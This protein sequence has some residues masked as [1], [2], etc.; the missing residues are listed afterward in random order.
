M[1]FSLFHHRKFFVVA[2]ALFIFSVFISPFSAFAKDDPFVSLQKEIKKLETMISSSEFPEGLEGKCS[3]ASG[4]KLSTDYKLS[5][6]RK[7]SDLSLNHEYA[8]ASKC[9]NNA[10][11]KSEE[12]LA[13]QVKA[14]ASSGASCSVTE[15]WK[16]KKQLEKIVNMRNSLFSRSVT[17]TDFFKSYNSAYCEED[18]RSK[19]F[20]ETSSLWK[21]FKTESLYLM[22]EMKRLDAGSISFWSLDKKKK[23]NITARANARAQN[24]VKDFA[25]SIH[26]EIYDP[27][28]RSRS[29]V[30][31]NLS[32]LPKGKSHFT[33]VGYSWADSF[34]KKAKEDIEKKQQEYATK[35]AQ[36]QSQFIIEEWKKLDTI[37]KD[38]NKYNADA[39]K[40]LQLVERY[41]NFDPALTDAVINSLDPFHITLQETTVLLKRQQK[42][43]HSVLNK[44]NVGVD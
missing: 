5:F 30:L 27:L 43:L 33:D 26:D 28:Y 39:Q 40:Y 6:T 18:V 19:I 35:K 12:E 44:Q 1:N 2:V 41:Q 10:M 16:A 7:A 8:E 23:E 11:K 13:K 38:T 37:K 29:S 22:K 36:H 32:N 21:K 34:S 17:D 4:A 9:F 20:E 42:A 3:N 24:Y 14:F 31:S 15:Y 25:D